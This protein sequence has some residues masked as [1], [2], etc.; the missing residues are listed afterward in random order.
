M[1]DWT[2]EEEAFFDAT[3]NGFLFGFVIILAVVLGV[4]IVWMR[5]STNLERD[6]L[7]KYIARTDQYEPCVNKGFDWAMGVDC[8]ALREAKEPEKHEQQAK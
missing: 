6:Y 8:S 2:R 4:L 1:S 5:A 7:R 3:I